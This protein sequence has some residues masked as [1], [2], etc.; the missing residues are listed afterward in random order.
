[1][2]LPRMVHEWKETR[3]ARVAKRTKR[4]QRIRI[5]DCYRGTKNAGPRNAQG[6]LSWA[7]PRSQVEAMAG[8]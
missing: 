7:R 2:K 6:A 4:T 5:A 1:M 3:R 8:Y